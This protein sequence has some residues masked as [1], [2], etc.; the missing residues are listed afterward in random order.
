[1][2]LNIESVH[3]KAD[4]KLILLINEKIDKLKEHHQIINTDVILKIGTKPENKIVEIKLSCDGCSFYAK[5][6]SE[7]FE[8]S[9][10]MVTEALRRQLRK[11][12]TRL[13][14]KKRKRKETF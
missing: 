2:N 5:K 1:M 3:F 6:N 10:D 4:K 9:M 13:L 14:D 12:K 8:Q 7:T 11:K